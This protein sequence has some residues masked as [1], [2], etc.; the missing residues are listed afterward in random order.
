V[1]YESGSWTVT[2]RQQSRTETKEGTEAEEGAVKKRDLLCQW[3][4]R[5]YVICTDKS[6]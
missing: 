5:D 2:K 4:D 1:L 3:L 6:K